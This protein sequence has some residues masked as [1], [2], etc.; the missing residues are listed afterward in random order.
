MSKTIF[1]IDSGEA[2]LTE[3]VK[4]LKNDTDYDIVLNTEVNVDVNKIESITQYFDT[5]DLKAVIIPEPVHIGVSIEDT[6]DEQWEQAFS[7]GALISML[8]TRAAGE[9]FKARGNGGVI[10]YLGSIHTE[11]PTG[12]D[13]L[14]SIQCSATQMMCR[15]AALAYGKYNVNCFYIQ[16][17]IMDSD[18][19]TVGVISNIYS[20]T[21]LRYPKLHTPENDHLNGLIDFL[22]TDA[23]SPLNGSDIKADEGLTMYYGNRGDRR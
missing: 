12:G 21:G 20:A 18:I 3:I 22:L 2:T 11:K 23:A 13:F 14:F 15:E 7:G 19:E 4:H 9:H 5:V 8:M 6:N 10:I 17:G 1:I 16:R